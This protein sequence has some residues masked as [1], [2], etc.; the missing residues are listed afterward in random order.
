MV[1]DMLEYLAPHQLATDLG[2]SIPCIERWAQGKN[3]PRKMGMKA[4]YAA[5]QTHSIWDSM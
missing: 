5:M 3:L 4:A 1:N 2:V